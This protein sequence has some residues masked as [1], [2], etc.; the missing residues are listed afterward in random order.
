ML[1][2]RYD[3]KEKDGLAYRLLPGEVRHRLLRNN[4]LLHWSLFPAKGRAKGTIVLLH[5]VA[6]N[7]SR[8]EE[9]A[10]K[11]PLH[12]CWD[13]IRMDLRGHAA[14]VC[15]KK[16]RLEDWCADVNAILDAA[17]VNNAVV[18]GH[19]L[20][21]QVAMNFA[22]RYSDRI[23]AL[24]LLDPLV[25][26]ALTPKARGMR[27]K[28]PMLCVAEAVTRAMNRLGFVRKIVA[29][30]LRSMDEQ[31]RTKI[32]A[33][34]EELKAFIRQYSSAKTDLQYIHLAPYLRDLLEVARRSPLASQ[35]KCPTLV[36]G[37]SAGTFTDEQ[38]MSKWV[39][40]LPQA[41]MKAVQCA[42]W[43]MT[44]CPQEVSEVIENWVAEVMAG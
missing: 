20:G 21:A 29:Q 43:P 39:S 14:S 31:A 36:I 2:T 38:A 8:W 32:A 17:E 10:E 34:G 19:S 12:E 22:A 9:F 18:I 15:S 42:H 11:T 40:G 1:K 26:E 5:G 28:V 24:V 16:A 7:G 37:S 33:G 25:T 44:E 13:I 35:I 27:R 6:S 23:R 4:A 3:L 41:Q 30:D